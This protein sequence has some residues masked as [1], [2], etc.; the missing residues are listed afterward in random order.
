MLV[1]ENNLREI[2]HAI[3]NPSENSIPLVA[4]ISGTRI[5][6]SRFC[7]GILWRFFYQIAN[8]ALGT[9]QSHLTPLQKALLN[10]HET[11]QNE[12]PKVQ[13]ALAHYQN[14]LK[15]GGKR[16]EIPEKE[17]LAAKEIITSWNCS[18]GPFLKLIQ[19]TSSKQRLFESLGSV[20]PKTTFDCP[21]APILREYQKIIDLENFQRSPLPFCSIKK[22]SRKITLNAHDQNDLDQW[23]SNLNQQNLRVKKVHQAV[24]NLISF[25]ANSPLNQEALLHQSGEFELF[26]EDRGCRIFQ[27]SD[28]KHLKWRDGLKKG[29]QFI[30]SH[31]EL[32]LGNELYINKSYGNHMRAYA[33]EGQPQRIARIAQNSYALKLHD[34]R[35]QKNC[36]YDIE[37]ALMLDISY[38]GKIAL[39][40]RM[41]GLLSL[42]WTSNQ[43]VLTYNDEIIVNQLAKLIKGFISS[44]STP[45]N[46]TVASIML[47]DQQKLKFI[48]PQTKCSFDFNALEEFIHACASDNK[49][50]LQELM[51]R[52]GLNNHPIAKFY[53][54]IVTGTLNDDSIAPDDLAGIYKIS[55]PKVV[56]RAINL[57]KHIKS[58]KN[59]LLNKNEENIDVNQILLSKYIQSKA[60]GVLV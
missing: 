31:S 54:D 19:K 56:D 50:I 34:L 57:A 29:Q 20:L 35:M 38:D 14:C 28:P 44:N 15:K 37:P 7:W 36:V 10:T 6:D 21:E 5:Y 11:F 23:I 40:E 43:G 26:L 53:R 22:S 32:I 51:T 33:I 55:D 52:S 49:L 2:Y 4:N 48:E 16:Y 30:L 9:D 39:Y 17:Y 45:S 27:K 58:K 1:L 12:I 3:R 8:W 13:T 46:F 24:Q 42:S 41:K 18:T 59:Q 60:A 25:Y 47:N